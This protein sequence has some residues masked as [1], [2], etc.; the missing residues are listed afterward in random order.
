MIDSNKEREAEFDLVWFWCHSHADC[1][2]KSSYMPMVNVAIFGP[3]L[4]YHDPFNTFII[5]SVEHRRKIEDVLHLV[6]F[7]HQK[8]LFASFADLKFSPQINLIFTKYTGAIY[9]NSY[10]RTQE[11]DTICRKFHLGI[12][13]EKEKRLISQIRV[14]AVKN[15]H[16]AVDAYI[17]AKRTIKQEKNE[18]SK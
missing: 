2:I 6:S 1:G 10:L 11:V 8:I 9:L 13:T 3:S 18:K 12:A 15:Y 16:A 14:E 7:K 5:N 4:D 17:K